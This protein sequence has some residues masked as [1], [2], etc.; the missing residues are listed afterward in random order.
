MAIS[1]AR[2]PQTGA[3][4]LNGGDLSYL[5]TVP[6]LPLPVNL[7]ITVGVFFFLER[8]RASG[9][10][11]ANMPA[12]FP[13]GPA[14]EP[15]YPGGSFD[16]LG[17]ASDPEALAELKVKEIKN[18]ACA[19]PVSTRAHSRRW[20]DARPCATS[21]ALTPTPPLSASLAGRLAMVSML[22]FAV[23]AAVTQ[24]GPWANWTKHLD[25]PFGYNLLTVLRAGERAATL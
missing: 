10:E 1:R 9:E 18:G 19:R 13:N 22:G 24:E 23:Q 16:P 25:D 5:G 2:A 15:L 11:Q 7:A 21:P 8:F 12:I 3:V 6:T 4:Q 20:R 14:A 17:L